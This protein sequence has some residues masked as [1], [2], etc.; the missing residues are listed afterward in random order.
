[1]TQIQPAI[2]SRITSGLGNQLF[3]Y[4]CG[5]NIA[6]RTG[7]ELY[8]DTSWFDYFQ[9]HE[10]RRTFRL[11]NSGLKTRGEYFSG[12]LRWIVGLACVNNLRI[13]SILQPMLR[14]LHLR[15]VNEDRKN[16]VNCLSLAREIPEANIFLNGYWQT[17]SYASHA[18]PSMRKQILSQRAY[19]PGADE[20]L[21]RIRR[22]KTAFLH[23]RRGDY[24]KFSHHML[25]PGYYKRATECLA[26][27]TG[28]NYQWLVFS[29]EREWCEDNLRWL[30][31]AAFV[32][33]QSKD[34]DIEDILLMAECEAGVIANSSFSWWG[35]M[36]SAHQ[37][38]AIACPS[39][40]TGQSQQ[41]DSL[42]FPD[43][44]IKIPNV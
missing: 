40:W 25:D 18:A 34:K 43:H 32:D 14:C 24:Q 2:I 22:K 29:E 15:F 20:W 36:L 27:Q 31:G 39:A 1:M 5:W 4:A 35:A 37:Q 10:P 6:G 21:Q 12:P 38:P 33:Y 16:H 19:S 42:L 9:T 11:A 23:V 28:Q 30:G 13:R 17:L 7:R 44:W 26:A 41:D 3:Q 8:L